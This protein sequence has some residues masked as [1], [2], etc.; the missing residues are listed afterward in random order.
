MYDQ[1]A[2]KVNYVDTTDAKFA[3]SES[4]N[5]MIFKRQT[6]EDME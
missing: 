1:D 2:Y 3:Y 5:D 4:F 6:E